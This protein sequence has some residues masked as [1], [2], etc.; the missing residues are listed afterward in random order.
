M[1]ESVLRRWRVATLL[2]LGLV[3]APVLAQGDRVVHIVVGFPAGGPVDFVARTLAEPLGKTLGA[4]VI[5][6]NKPGANGAIAAE[7]VAHAAADGSTLWLTSVGAIA[8][9]PVL[10][11][12]LGYDV[13]RD[14]APVSLVVN[15]DELLVIKG[16][17]PAANVADWLARAKAQGRPITLASSGIGSIPHLAGEQFALATK[18]NLL[19][20][21]YK[22]AAPAI[23]NVI[24]G[25]VDGFFGDIPGLVA[26]LKA[27][28]LKAIGLAAAKRSPVLPDVPTLAELGIPGVDSNNWYALYAPAKTPPERIAALNQALRSVLASSDVSSRL[29]AAGTEPAPSSPQAMADL[30]RADTQ[31]WGTLIRANGIKP[32]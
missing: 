1:R 23:T 6:D 31:K 25:Q 4:Q 16:D 17:N 3:S 28:K 11:E 5:V 29:L 27:G 14:F 26:H 19:H 32:E 18:A 7:A 10:Y 13:G 21:P 15:N 8:V 9:N 30:A 12:K 20:V 22:G 24:G 2:A